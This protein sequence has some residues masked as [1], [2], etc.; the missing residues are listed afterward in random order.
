[1]KKTDIAAVVLISVIT[2]IIAYFI[3][4]SILGDP[5]EESVVVTFMDIISPDVA[6]PDPEVFNPEAVNPTVEIYVGNCANG[7]TWDSSNQTCINPETATDSSAE[8][9][10]ETESDNSETGE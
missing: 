7:Q 1:M 6:Q 8:S 9:N 10:S 4:N 3:G 2:T 5:N